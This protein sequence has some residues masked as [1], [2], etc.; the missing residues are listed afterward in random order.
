MTLPVAREFARLGV[1]VMAIAPGIFNTPMVDELPQD[2]RDSLGEQAP[3][4]LA[5][6]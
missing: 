3:V 2:A 5:P 1:R 6:G 4:S